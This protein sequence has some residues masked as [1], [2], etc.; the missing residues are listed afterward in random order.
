M[1]NPTCAECGEPATHSMYLY[2][3]TTPLCQECFTYWDNYDG[4]PDREPGEP[5]ITMEEQYQ[6]AYRQKYFGEGL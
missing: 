6:K 2:F 1:N 5:P 4:P 3:E